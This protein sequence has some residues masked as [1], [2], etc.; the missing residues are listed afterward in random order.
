VGVSLSVPLIGAA[1]VTVVAVASGS[2]IYIF[3]NLR[4]Y[5]KFNLPTLE[6]NQKEKELW[7]LAKQVCVVCIST[8]STM[9]SKSILYT[10]VWEENF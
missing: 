8:L 2:L 7:M 6:V 4:P 10:R 9:M 1:M 3:K 5:F